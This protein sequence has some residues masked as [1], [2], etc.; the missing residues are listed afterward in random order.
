M[1]TRLILTEPLPVSPLVTGLE[2]S[3]EVFQR[4]EMDK[5]PQ[6]LLMNSLSSAESIPAGGEGY[7]QHSPQ[8]VSSALPV[9]VVTGP[10]PRRLSA[11]NRLH[12]EETTGKFGVFYTRS[13]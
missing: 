8:S 3:S 5:E 6:S 12:Q 2:F 9:S 7:F 10:C 1:E 4:P 13:F 11:L